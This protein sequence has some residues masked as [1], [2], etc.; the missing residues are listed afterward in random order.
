MS[1]RVIEQ[2]LD[3]RSALQLI[4]QAV[5]AGRMNLEES[6]LQHIRQQLAE[7]EKLLSEAG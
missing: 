2:W 5:S 7:L 4:L 1:T 6:E 3:K